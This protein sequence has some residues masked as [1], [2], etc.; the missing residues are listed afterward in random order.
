M[1]DE[2][3]LPEES[4]VEQPTTSAVSPRDQRR[5]ENR[6]KREERER[7]E[8]WQWVFSTPVGRREMWNAILGPQAG[9][10][11]EQRFGMGDT[12]FPDPNATF[13]ALGEQLLAQRIFLAWQL[14]H[15]EGVR[16]MVQENDPRF[17]QLEQQPK[18]DD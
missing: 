8:F 6:K 14:A 1:S 12:G 3:D 10:V 13:S 15:P 16:L 7:F 17:K 2:D 5:R 18:Q 9:H 11:F 4:P